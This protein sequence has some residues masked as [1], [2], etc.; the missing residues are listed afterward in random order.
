MEPLPTEVTSPS[1]EILA[2]RVS[3]V[4]QLIAG[5][6]MVLSFASFAVT[7]SWVVLP[8]DENVSTVS[9]SVTLAAT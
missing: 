6:T 9:D 4:T 3:D 1:S 5:L 2:T 7:V 8:N